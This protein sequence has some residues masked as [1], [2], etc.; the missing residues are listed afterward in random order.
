MKLRILIFIAFTACL[1]LAKYLAVVINAGQLGYKEH[2]VLKEG[3]ETELTSAFVMLLIWN[4]IF[5]YDLFSE[6]VSIIDPVIFAA[7]LGCMSGISISTI[8][9]IKFMPRGLYEKGIL[10]ETKVIMYSNIESYTIRPVLKRKYL[11]Y[12][13]V[14]LDNTKKHLNLIVAEQDQV[15]VNSLLKRFQVNKKG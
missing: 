9:T 4:V 6:T 12:R 7:M 8:Y 5:L 10:T 11:Q 14:S 1:G 13:F 15:K 2:I 3:R